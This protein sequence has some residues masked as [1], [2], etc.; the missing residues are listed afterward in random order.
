[1]LLLRGCFFLFELSDFLLFGFNSFSAFL[2]HL[3]SLLL[4]NLQGFF[5]ALQEKFLAFLLHQLAP[6]V[7]VLFLA[8]FRRVPLVLLQAAV[9]FL[10]QILAQHVVNLALVEVIFVANARH[11]IVIENLDVL[12]DVGAI[13]FN[14]PNLLL[15]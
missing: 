11:S 1:M 3:G 6:S 14:Q 4:T 8:R 7:I 12:A 5:L 2:A 10:G 15:V 9:L 13:A